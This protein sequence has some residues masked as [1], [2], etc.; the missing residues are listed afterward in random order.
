MAKF[1]VDDAV[2]GSFD[3]LAG[4]MRAKRLSA[5]LPVE[6]PAPSDGADEDPDD[7]GDDQE[8]EDMLADYDKPGKPDEEG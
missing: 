2:R 3:S 4:S 7:D 8:L 6:P 1:N 5:E